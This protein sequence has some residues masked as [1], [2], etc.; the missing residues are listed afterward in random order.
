MVHRFLAYPNGVEFTLT[1]LLRDAYEWGDFPWDLR[2][3][4]RG[5]SLPDEFLRFGILLSDGSKWTN[6]DRP[7]PSPDEEP[8]GPVVIGRGGGGGGD[9]WEMGQWM[10]PLPPEGTMTFVGSWPVRDISEQRA[11][12]DATEIR[13]R[14]DEGETIWET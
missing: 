14:A 12:V 6:L 13:H 3:R 10:W 4:P 1:L 8:S 7:F 5:D 11:E 2:R 9:S